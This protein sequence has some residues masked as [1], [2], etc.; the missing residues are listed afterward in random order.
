MPLRKTLPQVTD[1]ISLGPLRVSPVCVG[2][3]RSPTTI[4]A[5]FDA[6]MN[7][8]FVT[9]DMHWVA[10]ENTRRG[11]KDLCARGGGVR[12]DIVVAAVS[13]VTQPEFCHAPFRDAVANMPF[14][15]TMDVLVAGGAYG[16]EFNARWPVFEAH[17]ESSFLGSRAVGASFHDRRAA[18]AAMGAGKVDIAFVRYSPSHPGAQ[19]EVFQKVGVQAAPLLFTFNSTYGYVTDQWWPPPGLP[20]AHPRPQVAHY[21]RFA[22]SSPA[23]HGLLC[24]PSTPDHVRALVDALAM[25][26]VTVDETSMLSSVA[27]ALNYPP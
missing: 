26:P 25:G 13:Y 22:L 4:S 10:Y 9:T 5:A 23:V 19:T 17:R 12:D 7:F 16:Y 8:F 27:R 2:I 15:R 20:A 18:A 3:V 11:L 21:Y 1:R 24:A 6:G 14:L